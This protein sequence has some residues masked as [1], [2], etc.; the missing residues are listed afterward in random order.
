MNSRLDFFFLNTDW[1]LLLLSFQFCLLQ[2]KTVVRRIRILQMKAL[3][4]L[5]FFP[6]FIP[7]FAL[8]IVIIKT[9][10]VSEYLGSP[11]IIFGYW[12][13]FTIVM[14]I[15]RAFLSSKFQSP[16]NTPSSIRLIYNRL[17][18]CNS[19][20]QEKAIFFNSDRSIGVVAGKS[21]LTIFSSLFV[22]SN[23]VV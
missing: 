13:I 5:V 1:G 16:K 15:V 22:L 21:H 17:K 9:W 7:L 2:K 3:F 10:A 12:S 8:I 23:T 20:I 4:N 6:K 14:L 18:P 19:L 11:E